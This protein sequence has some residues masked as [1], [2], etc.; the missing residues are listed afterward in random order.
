MRRFGPGPEWSIAFLQTDKRWSQG[1]WTFQENQ[2]VCSGSRCPIY[3]T[4]EKYRQ[5]QC[6]L[7]RCNITHGV[8]V[9]LRFECVKASLG[10][11]RAEPNS[12]LVSARSWFPGNAPDHKTS[13]Q[14]WADEEI[15][16]PSPAWLPPP[17]D[18]VNNF[19][20]PA[21]SATLTSL[22]AVTTLFVLCAGCLPSMLWTP[23]E[24]AFVLCSVAPGVFSI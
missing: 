20:A 13:L 5:P 2:V 19:P 24:Q 12:G 18:G 14:V 1:A 10:V 15:R 7:T 22:A 11:P 3:R 21:T 17:P 9:S 16:K 8:W 23:W 6:Q 4:S